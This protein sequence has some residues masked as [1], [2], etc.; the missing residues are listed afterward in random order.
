M[1]R[2]SRCRPSARGFTLLE[3]LIV[4]AVLGVALLMAM[5]VILQ[6]S[7]AGARLEMHVRALRAAESVLERL[8]GGALPLASGR[9]DAFAPVLV[10][11]EVE[12]AGPPGLY[13]AV[14][15]ATY[16][17]QGRLQTRQ[18]TTQVWRHPDG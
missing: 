16:I 18:L 15:R 10:W 3:T 6:Q 7:R 8:R 11:L 4:L 9:V 5:G 12:P 1:A 17:F 14:A 2:A 13:T